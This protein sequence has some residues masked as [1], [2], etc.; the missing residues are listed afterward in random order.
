[1]FLERKFANI[2]KYIPIDISMKLGV[3]EHILLCA[4]FSTQ[5]IELY[6]YLFREF[7]D[8]FAWSYKGMPSIDP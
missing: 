8:M 6:T 2:L 4:Y 1:M 5:E 7:C 3:V